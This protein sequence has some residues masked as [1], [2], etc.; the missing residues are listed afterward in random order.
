MCGG[1]GTSYTLGPWVVS[2]SS[3]E[4]TEDTGQPVGRIALEG[5]GGPVSRRT[6]RPAVTFYPPGRVREGPYGGLRE[7]P[8]DTV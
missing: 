8:D 4:D 6:G 5:V 1:K 3:P 7:C 2:P